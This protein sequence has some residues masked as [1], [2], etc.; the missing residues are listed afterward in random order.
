MIKTR[1]ISEHAVSGFPTRDIIKIMYLWHYYRTPA[2]WFD[3]YNAE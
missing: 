3:I 1:T 2:M